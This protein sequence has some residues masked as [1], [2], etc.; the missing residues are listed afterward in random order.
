LD[1][2]IIHVGKT[3]FL[4]KNQGLDEENIAK[5]ILKEYKGN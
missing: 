4:L 3:D 5:T 2:K 1:L